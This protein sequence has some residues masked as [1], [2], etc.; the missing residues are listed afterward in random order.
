MKTQTAISLTINGQAIA[1]DG[2]RNLLEVI[3]KAK[4][5]L[6][7][8]CY[9]SELSIYGAC[10]LC[11]VEVEGRGTL[12]ACSTPPEEGMRI[13]THTPEIRNL[14]KVIV[15]LLL[16]NHDNNCPTCPKSANCQLQSLAR[17]LGITQIR[18]KPTAKDLTV[19]Q[20]TPSL[21]RNPSKCV[22]CGDCVR[23]CSE[24]QG[25][26]AIDFAYRGS[27]VAVLPAFGK[28]LESVEC[29]YCGQ[30][31]RVCPTGA[32]TPKSEIAEVW[33]ALHDPTKTVVAQIAPAVR[34]AVGEEFGFDPGDN[35]SALMVA[36]LKRLGFDRVYDTSFTAD[37]TVLEESH[38]F[39]GRL[40]NGG[41]MPLL[42]SCCPA[43]VKFVEQ[44]Y[45]E[46]LPNLSSCKSPQQMFGAVAKNVLPA[47]LNVP[48]RELVVVSIM[49]CTAKKFEARREEFRPAGQAEV[50]YVLTTQE[51]CRMIEE[52]GLR[53]KQLEPAEFDQPFGV[54]TGAGV[55]FGNSGGVSEAVLRYVTEAVTGK[56]SEA[57]E[58][59]VVRGAEGVREA[60]LELNGR[61]VKLAVVNGLK[62]ARQVLEAVRSGK[63]HYDLIEVMACPGG[64][65]GGAGQP[66]NLS[67]GCRTQRKKGLY[68]DDKNQTLHKSQDNP[69]VQ[70]LYKST[71][72]GVGSQTAH[73]LLHTHYHSRRRTEGEELPL[74]V[75]AATQKLKIGVCVG[76]SC[77][78]RGSQELLHQLLRLVEENHWQAF[79]SV[80]A[81]FCHEQCAQGPTVRVNDEILSHASLEEVVAKIQTY[82]ESIVNEV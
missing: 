62:N 12:P 31:A 44:Y 11:M 59:T 30:C 63:A 36:A 43:W 14:R 45:P 48:V 23:V 54:K 1:V 72:S 52:S 15:E 13:Q 9:H 61:E 70:E 49:P 55:I 47:Q 4:I 29:V 39:I 20:T 66:V 69:G 73:H 80:E 78:L 67:R 24:I 58:F 32:L 18:F 57:Y 71:L 7:T 3:R 19:D 75:P 77:Y 41:V 50:D 28:N 5:D 81:S 8:F 34:V 42:T 6:P 26:G 53:Y 40:Q 21:V 2:E 17:K 65:I 51:L 79:V 82:L 16:A 68:E 64:C 35:T 33:E 25:I 46:F 74:V 56:K 60:T 76:T 38:E 22:L 27:Q 37:L 10:R